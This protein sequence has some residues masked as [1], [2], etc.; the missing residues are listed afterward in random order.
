MQQVMENVQARNFLRILES[1]FRKYMDKYT[2]PR[3]DVMLHTYYDQVSIC[4][5]LGPER[6]GFQAIFEAS[7]RSGNSWNISIHDLEFEEFKKTYT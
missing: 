1:S 6:G 2:S 5:D 7:Q 4:A 3:G